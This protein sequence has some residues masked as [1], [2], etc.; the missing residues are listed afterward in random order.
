MIKLKS[1]IFL[2]LSGIIFLLLFIGTPFFHNH[3][4]D[5]HVHHDCPAFL[6]ELI[7]QSCVIFLFIG[8]ITI[9]LS[10]ENFYTEYS[11]IIV[12]PLLFLSARKRAPPAR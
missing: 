10:V 3:K 6:L 4:A 2:V 1:K 9:F 8:C 12:L 7:L 5:L 11:K